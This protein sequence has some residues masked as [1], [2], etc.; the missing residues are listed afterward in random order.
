MGRIHLLKKC[1]GEARWSTR[2]TTLSEKFEVFKVLFRLRYLIEIQ[3]R[4]NEQAKQ[5]IFGFNVHGTSNSEMLYLFREIFMNGQYRFDSA[6]SP[7]ILDCGANIGMAVLFFKKLYPDCSIT[8]FEPNPV[9]FRLLEMNVRNNKLANVQLVNKALSGKEGVIDFYSNK[10]NSLISSLEKNR[11]GSNSLKID[12]TRLSNYLAGTTFDFAKI[13][14][15]GAEWEIIRDLDES[16]TIRHIHQFIF[17]YHHNI[18][19][20]SLKLSEFLRIFEINDFVYNVKASYE[21]LGEVQD[22][23]INVVA[24]VRSGAEGNG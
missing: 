24:R 1:L 6:K 5:N 15:E 21:L 10:D 19:G 4:G 18:R 7:K 2:Y 16:K 17:E 20:G 22:I 12:T 13:D 9:V 11:G 3:G 8:A 23:E 14:V